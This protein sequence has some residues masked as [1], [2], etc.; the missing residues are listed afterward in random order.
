MK[1]KGCRIFMTLQAL[2]SASETFRR[3]K[4]NRSHLGKVGSARDLRLSSRQ[5]LPHKLHDP[6]CPRKAG[7][8][9]KWE[10]NCFGFYYHCLGEWILVWFQRR[11]TQTRSWNKVGSAGSGWACREG[12]KTLPCASTPRGLFPA[13]ELKTGWVA[14]NPASS[15]RVMASYL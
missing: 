1:N 11:L 6:H 2:V 5:V 3:W 10:H 14:Q 8:S 15:G 4:R 9:R 13:L 7:C 12:S